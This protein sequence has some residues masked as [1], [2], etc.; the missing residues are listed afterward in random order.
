MQMKVT[1]A[2]ARM[3]PNPMDLALSGAEDQSPAGRAEMPP[4]LLWAM[5]PGGPA[6]AFGLEACFLRGTGA[7]PVKL[8]AITSTHSASW[9]IGAI[10]WFQE[11]WR[12]L[13]Q[14]WPASPS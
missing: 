12:W 13:P 6:G 8:T 4:L 10:A 2:S 5:P 9:N 14:P 1:R 7:T 11:R 3:A